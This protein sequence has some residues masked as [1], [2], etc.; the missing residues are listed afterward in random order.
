[1]MSTVTFAANDTDSSVVYNGRSSKANGLSQE[2]FD[3]LKW[4]N[5]LPDDL[6][7]L[8]SHKPLE[9]SSSTPYKTTAIIDAV[10]F[11]TDITMSLGA[12]LLPTSGYKSVYNPVIGN[13]D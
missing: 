6:K 13:K 9:L 1:M 2:T 11:D 7:E 10:A 4:Y 12:T 3:W 5:E 8:V